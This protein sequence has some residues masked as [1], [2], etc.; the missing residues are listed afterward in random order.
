MT[1]TEFN[2]RRSARRKIVQKREELRRTRELVDRGEADPREAE[3]IAEQLA[4]L[5][6]H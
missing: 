2:E 1:S 4:D 6:K 3:W 5:R